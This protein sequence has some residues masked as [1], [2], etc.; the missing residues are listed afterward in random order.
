MSTDPS[1][2]SLSMPIELLD[3]SPFNNFFI[4]GIILFTIIGLG[5]IIIAVLVIRKHKYIRWLVI[6][7][8]GSLVIWITVQVI[9]I[10]P[11]NVLQVIYFLT[12]LILVIVASLRPAQ[13]TGNTL[14]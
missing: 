8:G 10:R 6:A 13:I 11:I 5:S 1:G 2:K 3:N 4:P 9:M 12:G 7:S 14:S